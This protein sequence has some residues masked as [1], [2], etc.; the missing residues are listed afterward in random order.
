[1]PGMA[2][3]I[4][5]LVRAAGVSKASEIL[6]RRAF[7]VPGLVTVMVQGHKLEVRPADSDL[8]VLS[9]IFG[10]EDTA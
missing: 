4:K 10:S 6:F 9:Q 5:G 8:F 2:Y 3:H 1:M 7:N